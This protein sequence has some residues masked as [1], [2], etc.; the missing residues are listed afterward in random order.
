MRFLVDHLLRSALV[1]VGV[2]FQ[3][4][5]EIQDVDDEQD[6][7]SAT[8]D[9]QYLFLGQTVA[10]RLERGIEC[11]LDFTFV[12]SVAVLRIVYVQSLRVRAS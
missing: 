11:C 9:F 12:S 1:H 5:E 3:L 8:A 4:E 10:S 7:A 6:D 2:R